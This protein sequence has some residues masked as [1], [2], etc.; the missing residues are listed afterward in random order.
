MPDRAQRIT[1]LLPTIDLMRAVYLP[2]MTIAERW[3]SYVALTACAARFKLWGALSC[4]KQ[5]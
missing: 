2:G 1:C 3:S 5:A 4:R